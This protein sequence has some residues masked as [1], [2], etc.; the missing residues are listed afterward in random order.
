MKD[1]FII[2]V[3]V[4]V[5]QLFAGV[6]RGPSVD[7][8]LL[9]FRRSSRRRRRRRKKQKKQKQEQESDAEESREVGNNNGGGGDL[10]FRAHQYNLNQTHHIDPKSYIGP[11]SSLIEIKSYMV[12][13]HHSIEMILT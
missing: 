3:D 7:G 2:S 13:F 10:G 8:S 9:T 4:E 1:I 5:V 11:K 12:P 6:K